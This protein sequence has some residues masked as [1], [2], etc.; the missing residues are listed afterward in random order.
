MKKKVI[1]SILCSLVL[2]SGICIFALPNKKSTAKGAVFNLSTDQSAKAS[3][4]FTV[5]LK[6]SSKT[7]LH[8]IDAYL[9]YDKDL[10]EFIKSDC[11][12]ITGAEGT[13]HV[14]DAFTE[15]CTEKTYKLTFTGLQLGTAKFKI[16]DTSIEEY[17]NLDQEKANAQSTS[18]E[19][20]KN[21]SENRDA[22]LSDFIVGTG[23]LSQKFDPDVYEY[24]VT[25]PSSTD[26]FICS[27]VPS[28]EDAVVEQSGPETLKKGKNN[29]VFTVTAPSLD[30]KEYHITVI[31][32]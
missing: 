13:L 16:Y 20:V 24:E 15:E 23:E 22:Q 14:T 8:S 25:V 30:K 11:D 5:T 29:Y 10:V 32:K 2:V 31:R 19:I 27:S 18:I 26:V 12:G 21:K 7:P 9:S 3:K 6:M 1:I 17:E 4:E 28:C